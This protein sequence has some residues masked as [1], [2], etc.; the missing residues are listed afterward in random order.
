VYDGQG[1]NDSE[2]SKGDLDSLGASATANQ[3][4]VDNLTKKLQKKNLQLKH[5]KN[6]MQRAEITFQSKMNFGIEQ[7]R[8][9]YQQQM[10]QL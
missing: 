1:Q 9:S 6:E 2:F 4:S 7:I 3:W 10:K 5:V 8:L